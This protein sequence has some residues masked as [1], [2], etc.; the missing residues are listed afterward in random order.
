M[1]VVYKIKYNESYGPPTEF[2]RVCWRW[3]RGGMRAG[4]QEG[5]RL[6]SSS[7]TA[8]GR[9]NSGPL[10]SYKKDEKKGLGPLQ[11]PSFECS[12]L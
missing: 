5:R 10:L 4:G 9:G 11:D 8:H 1:L 6:M 3:G 2:S 7:T 12:S